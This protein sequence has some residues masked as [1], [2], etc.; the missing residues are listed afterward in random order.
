MKVFENK[1]LNI[2]TN[3]LT[4]LKTSTNSVA[5]GTGVN[6]EEMGKRIEFAKK[7]ADSDQGSIELDD[8]ELILIK[9]LVPETKWS[10][11]DEEI[12]NFVKYV[13]EL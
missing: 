11:M 5:E 6:Y 1:E 3:Y 7:I 13:V 2:G 8:G 10:V 12:Y 9:R 4:L